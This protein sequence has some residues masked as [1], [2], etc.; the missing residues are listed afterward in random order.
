MDTNQNDLF[1][2]TQTRWEAVLQKDPAADEQFFFA[3]KSTGIFCRPTCKSRLPNQQNVLFFDT[4]QEAEAAGFRP[5]KRCQ[6]KQPDFPQENAKRMIKACEMMEQAEK[7]PTLQELADYVG[8]SPFYFQRLFRETVGVTPKQ[9]FIQKRSE[10]IRVQLQQNETVT[11][12]IFNAGYG[13]SAQFYGQAAE[14]LGMKPSQYQNGGKG[15]SMMVTILPCY[16]GWVLIAATANGVCLIE[17]ADD[18]HKLEN[19]LKNVFPAARYTDD[20]PMFSTWVKETLAFLEQPGIGLSLP[21]DIQG[22][23]FQKRVWMALREV[24]SGTRVSYSEVARRIGQSKAAR[25]VAQ[26]CAANH[27][28]VAIPCHRVVREN[29]DLGGYRWGVDR[30]QK[31]LQRE[32]ENLR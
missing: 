21:L 6:P 5:C 30:K 3:V 22:T 26:A 28:A 4:F 19:L 12:A 9:Y 11:D 20:N 1:N 32:S 29:G 15:I 27:L 2:T 7:C 31:L 14:I 13:S 16:L 8:L 10:R 17:F 18:P 24:P 25:A 23:A